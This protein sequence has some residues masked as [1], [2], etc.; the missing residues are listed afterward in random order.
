M[1][2]KSYAAFGHRFVMLN[3]SPKVCGFDDLIKQRSKKVKRTSLSV[4]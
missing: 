2:D 1:M 3:R 4:Y